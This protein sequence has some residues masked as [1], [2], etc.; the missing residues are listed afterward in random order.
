MHGAGIDPAAVKAA[1][2]DFQDPETG[3]SVVAMDQVTEI[4]VTDEAIS[5][6][7]GLTSYSAPLWQETIDQAQE[8]LGRAFP[9]V[10]D[11]HVRR[12]DHHRP[13]EKIGEIGLQAK[14]VIAVG[15]GKGGVGKSTVAAALAYGLQRA[16]CQ[17]GLMDAD[18]YGPSIPHLLGIEGRPDVIE[19]RIQPL[20]KDGIPRDVDGVSR[21]RRR[22]GCLARADAARCDYAVLCATRPGAIWTT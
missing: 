3:R 1:L 14:S 11:V 13:A 18:V 20:V 15:S 17:V 19:N 5:L 21:A 8:H 7:L 22:S 10:R 9:Q 16:G 4:Q 2:Q 6:T 12:G